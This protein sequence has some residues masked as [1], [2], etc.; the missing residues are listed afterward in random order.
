MGRSGAAE[1]LS[2][3]LPLGPFQVGPDP[4]PVLGPRFHVAA[5]GRLDGPEGASH[6]GVPE[7]LPGVPWGVGADA[8]EVERIDQGVALPDPTVQVRQG[9]DP[10]L[11]DEGKPQPERAQ[12]GRVVQEVNAV[13][14]AGHEPS[15]DDARFGVGHC[16]QCS[17]EAV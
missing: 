12:E 10:L 17:G 6:A 15:A 3:Q 13:E 4:S 8:A 1:P 11:G 14:G 5:G 7:R 16:A 9:P 2:G